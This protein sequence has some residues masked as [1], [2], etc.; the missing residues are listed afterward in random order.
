MRTT[1]LPPATDQS[2][3]LR[4]TAVAALLL[5]VFF[6]VI[7]RL[8][9]VQIVDGDRYMA[10]AERNRVR[11][12]TLE[13]AR[14]RVLDLQGRVLVD[15]RQVNVI[16]VDVDEMGT[17]RERVLA[18]LA[19]LLGTDDDEL[20]AR[21]DAA[22]RAPGQPVPVAFDVPEHLAL[23]IWEQQTTRLPG[24]YAQLV[25]RRSYPYGQLA[26]HVLGYTGQITAEHLDD[27][28]FAG[29][30]AT[31]QIGLTGVERRYDD[32]LRGTPGRL[33]LQIDATGDVVRQTAERPP[34]PGADVTLTIDVDIQRVAE[35]AL[36][37]GLEVARRTA[38]PEHRGDGRFA[39]VAGAVVV[40]DPHTGA[41]EAL[42]SAP[43]FA[44]EAFVGGID[45]QDYATLLA[46]AS[47][48]P[49]VNRAVASTYPPGSVFKPVSAAAA[50]R[51]GFVTPETTIDCPG[52][53]RWAPGDTVFRNWTSRD[54][55][56]M[57]LSEA[58]AQ[59]CDTVF[60]ELAKRMWLAE[61]R[62][63]R[64]DGLLGDEARR[65][66]YGQVTGV[67]LPG[68]RGGVVPGRAWRRQFWEDHHAAACAQARDAT[69]DRRE[70]LAEL[71]SPAG[72]RWRGGDAVNLSIG[73]GDL[74]VSPLQV[75]VSMAAV[76]TG[77][78]VPAPHVVRGV[79]VD[80]AVTQ[81]LD[82]EPAHLEVIR[83]GL[84]R[85]VSSDGT[86]GAAFVDAA[87]P[88]AGKTGTAE[89]G[90]K[91]PYAWFA[92]YGPTAAPRHVVV[93]LIEQGG[94]GSKVAAPVAREIFDGLA[95]G[96]SDSVASGNVVSFGRGSVGRRPW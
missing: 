24:V 39:A 72:G 85:V 73:Q 70:M 59:S 16:A 46:P 53:W 80:R 48:A 64:S 4:L 69:T 62:G 40:L 63:M 57:T 68:E 13:A 56:A 33:D 3:R 93:V 6:V 50:L 77:A 5:S 17:R 42:A 82:L 88:V 14:G 21:L 66:G 78:P 49:L 44:P 1:T 95:A 83:A 87:M 52:A 67:D 23:R 55:G 92:G 12:V 10:L 75:A 27:P 26:A 89:A 11:S 96:T 22:P 37:R 54:M 71:C 51:H 31:A 84:E 35:D 60:Y 43:S 34:T 38:D 91:Q 7:A 25:P 19:R 79:V 58:L 45:A 74:L 86:A 20:R 15:N 8:W 32:V 29:I 90:S 94:S 9:Y 30:D 61:G 2:V 18:E 47:H 41:V 76:A 28:A 65:F 81:A 36:A